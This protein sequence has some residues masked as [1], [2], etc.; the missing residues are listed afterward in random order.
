MHQHGLRCAERAHQ[1]LQEQ[2]A[3]EHDQKTACDRSE[4]RAGRAAVGILIVLLAQTDA[5]DAACAHRNAEAESL[6]QR[7]QRKHNADSGRRARRDLG[8][9]VGVGSVVDD[10][11]EL[12][13]NSGDRERRDQ[14]RDWHV[15]H[16]LVLRLAGAWR[17]DV[18]FVQLASL[19]YIR[20]IGRFSTKF[21]I[22]WTPENREQANAGP[23]SVVIRLSGGAKSLAGR[24]RSAQSARLEMKSAAPAGPGTKALDEVF[25]HRGPPRSQ[26]AKLPPPG[27]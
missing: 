23:R 15:E 2:K 7:L 24:A 21:G 14:L 19:H 17:A 12:A 22:R 11:N 8:D 9:K 16:S 18:V 25:F 3:E 26:E 4:N 6:D 27:G 1:R 10:G 13:C 20:L 5:D